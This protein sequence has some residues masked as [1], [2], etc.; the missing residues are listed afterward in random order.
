MQDNMF[1]QN[2]IITERVGALRQLGRN[3]L[4]GK[5]ASAIIAIV[6]FI[7]CMYVPVIIFNNLFGYNLNIFI[8][9]VLGPEHPYSLILEQNTATYGQ[10]PS[11][12]LLSMVYV[13]AV[14]GAFTLGV[15]LFYLASFRGHAVGPRD[16]FLGFERFGKALGLYLFMFLFITLWT[17]LFIIPG[18][19][20][21]IRYSQA[22]FVLAD[23]PEKSIRQCMDESKMMMK[24]NKA[25][26]FVLSLSFI[27][28]ILLCSIP[29]GILNSIAQS[30]TTN[31]VAIACVGVVGN[32][33]MA[34]LYAYVFSTLAGFYEI[35]AGHLIKETA[36]TPVTAEQIDVEAPVETIEEII[37]TVEE[38]EI[39]DR[40]KEGKE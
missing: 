9:M 40:D 15:C 5:W 38:N 8:T 12:S 7:L 32:L 26:Y 30:I 36:P 22:F 35:L 24:G 39:T 4:R 23:D 20:A 21:S 11:I 31:E 16:I 10:M 18:I 34:P 1:G 29:A 2:I 6:I 13:L 14:S 19:I 17:I 37:E 33:F 28:W 3:A 25:K 27:G